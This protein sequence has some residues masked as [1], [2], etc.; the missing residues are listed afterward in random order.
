MLCATAVAAAAACAG[1]VHRFSGLPGLVSLAGGLPPAQSLPLQHLTA[2]LHGGTEVQ[3]GQEGRQVRARQGGGARGPS[4]LHCA[5]L[6]LRHLNPLAARF[7]PVR[8]VATFAVPGP[9][10]AVLPGDPSLHPS[11]C[12][13]SPPSSTTSTHT[14][15]RRCW[16]GWSG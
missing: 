9:P 8:L 5:A 6:L 12:S 7:S 2:T 4:A 16:R 15:T 11:F 1:F 10:P 3:L 13:F 14:A